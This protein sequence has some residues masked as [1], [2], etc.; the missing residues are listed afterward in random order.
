MRNNYKTHTN[1]KVRCKVE[2][3]KRLTIIMLLYISNF[4]GNLF[5]TGLN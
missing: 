1:F 3:E 2:R 4:K 5:L